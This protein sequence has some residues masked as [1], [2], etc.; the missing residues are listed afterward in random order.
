M[1]T[2]IINF[3]DDGSIS[4]SYDYHTTLQ[5]F[6]HLKRA[7]LDDKIR[8]ISIFAHGGM[9]SEANGMIH[10]QHFTDLLKETATH[11]V[12]FVWE[13]GFVNAF[14]LDKNS[15]RS[16][17]LFDKVMRL[18]KTKRK[19]H[20]HQKSTKITPHV[21]WYQ[22]IL[23]ILFKISRLQVFVQRGWM[24]MKQ[25]SLN[26]FSPSCDQHLYAGDLLLQTLQEVLVQKPTLKINLVAHSTGSILIGDMLR[27]SAKHFPDITFNNISLL[28]PANTFEHFKESY[29]TLEK[30]YTE[31]YFFIL[32]D[33]FEKRDKF[34]WYFFN[35]SILYWISNILESRFDTP[36][37]GMQRHIELD[38]P[39]HDEL[40]Y[41][42]KY[43]LKEH[44]KVHLLISDNRESDD[45]IKTA[46]YKHGEFF[47]EDPYTLES[48]K[49]IS[50]Y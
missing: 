12:T 46:A 48:L 38:L 18:F 4:P 22:R 8:A 47:P 7:L 45:F 39:H 1:R 21:G 35:R 30:K 43:F 37:V 19:V 13:S 42:V 11:P 29:V 33:T 41:S 28:A 20:T 16:S 27:Y 36:I 5:D 32:N 44:A 3:G 6:V 40:H 26:T 49:K 9:V 2:N 25:K 50:C 10:A 24:G 14:Y 31:L 15:P 17:N 34:A 23:H